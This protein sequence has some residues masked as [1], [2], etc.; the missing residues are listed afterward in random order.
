MCIVLIAVVIDQWTSGVSNLRDCHVTHASNVSCLVLNEQNA[1]V[2]MS[3]VKVVSDVCHKKV[4]ESVDS[5]GAILL[6][7]F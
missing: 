3:V 5:P 2:H 1:K 4:F 7:P 6:K